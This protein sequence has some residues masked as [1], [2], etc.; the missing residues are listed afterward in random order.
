MQLSATVGP[1]NTVAV[2]HDCWVV[3]VYLLG[4]Y[5]VTSCSGVQVYPATSCK[6]YTPSLHCKEVLIP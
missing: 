2:G 6:L 1:L 3:E 4:I 5:P